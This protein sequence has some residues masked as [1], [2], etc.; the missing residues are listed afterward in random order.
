MYYNVVK[1]QFQGINI[2]ITMANLKQIF[3]NTLNE[4]S[5]PA[6]DEREFDQVED[7]AALQKRLATTDTDPTALD[8][9][10]GP[11]NVGYHAEVATA[12][13][14]LAEIDAFIKYLNDTQEGSINA[15]INVLDRDN[16]VFKGI[17]SRTS[18]KFARVSSDLAEL[19]EI[20]AGFII[21]SDRKAKTIRMQDSLVISHLPLNEQVIERLSRYGFE[22]VGYN[23]TNTTYSLTLEGYDGNVLRAEVNEDGKVNGEDCNLYIE[24]ITTEYELEPIIIEESVIEEDLVMDEKILKQIKDIDEKLTHGWDQ[25]L[26]SKRRE[27]LDKMQKPYIDI[28]KSLM[29]DGE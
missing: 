25:D 14:W 2:N 12:E 8:V 19:K 15:Q 10:S 11:D 27:L 13:G 7:E 29:N 28:A 5:A 6:P 22:V 16:S 1:I 18:D 20:I 24:R 26:Y 17:A 4:A 21:S 3:L 23:K 9:D